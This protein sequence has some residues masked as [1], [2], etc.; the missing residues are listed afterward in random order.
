MGLGTAWTIRATRTEAKALPEMPPISHASLIM[1]QHLW[2]LQ[3]VLMQG[4][5]ESTISI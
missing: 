5:T 4:N 1:L 2:P 3:G